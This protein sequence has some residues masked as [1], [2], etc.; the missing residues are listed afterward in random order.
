MDEVSNALLKNQGVIGGS[1]ATAAHAA[2]PANA[3]RPVRQPWTIV[4]DD[5][6]DAEFNHRPNGAST[7]CRRKSPAS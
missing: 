2:R 1:S 3:T 4:L 7:I 6:S 5:C